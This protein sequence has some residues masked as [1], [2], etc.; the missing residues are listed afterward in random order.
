[1]KNQILIISLLIGIVLVS[2]C[3]ED[4][5]ISQNTITDFEEL[6]LSQMEGE[7]ITVRGI[8]IAYPLFATD[9]YGIHEDFYGLRDTNGFDIKFISRGNRHIELREKYTIYGIVTKDIDW[10]GYEKY[11]DVY[12]IKEVKE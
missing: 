10:A 3:I 1:M 9:N 6:D 12:F 4:Y 5:G 8:A 7:K 2:G 11:E